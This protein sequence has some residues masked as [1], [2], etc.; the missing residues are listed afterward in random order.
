MDTTQRL[1]MLRAAHRRYLARV[2]AR[3]AAATRFAAQVTATVEAATE[4]PDLD[5]A[6]DLARPT[7]RVRELLRGVA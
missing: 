2:A 4:P 1:A 6:D 5:A 7:V 3:E